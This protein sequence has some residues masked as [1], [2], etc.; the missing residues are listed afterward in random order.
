MRHRLLDFS[1][2]NITTNTVDVVMQSMSAPQK[3]N[4]IPIRLFFAIRFKVFLCYVEKT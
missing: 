2:M 3:K 4:R 1:S